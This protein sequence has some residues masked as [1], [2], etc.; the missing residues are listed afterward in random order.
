MGNSRK[1]FFI[2]I[3]LFLAKLLGNQPRLVSHYQPILVLLIFE[4]A[5][6]TDGMVLRRRWHQSLNLISLKNFKLLMHRIDP[7]RIRKS[8][9]NIM[10]LKREK[11]E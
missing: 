6:C 7:V 11:T 4:N 5:F 10:G 9:S 1:G 8:V 2:I 3:T